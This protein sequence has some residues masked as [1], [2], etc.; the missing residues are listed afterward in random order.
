MKQLLLYFVF[1]GAFWGYAFYL[2]SLV[3]LATVESLLKSAR[4]LEALHPSLSFELT[5]LYQASLFQGHAF[6]CSYLHKEERRLCVSITTK[7]RYV[8]NACQLLCSS[9]GLCSMPCTASLL[10]Y[11][12]CLLLLPSASNLQRAVIISKCKQRKGKACQEQIHSWLYKELSYIAIC[13]GHR[14]R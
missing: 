1:W 2:F 10:L 6:L 13:L 7:D 11:F 12:F 9:T 14:E 3:F 4:R 8:L 5:L